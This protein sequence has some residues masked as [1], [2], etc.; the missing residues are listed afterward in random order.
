MARDPLTSLV[1]LFEGSIRVEHL[2]EELVCVDVADLARAHEKM[3]ELQIDVVG[4]REHSVIAGYIC[5]GAQEWAHFRAAELV[6]DSASLRDTLPILRERERLFVLKRNE[7]RWIITRADLQKAPFRL[8]C[9]GIVTLLEIR[10]LDL[11]RETYGDG[12]RDHLT[13]DR[14]EACERTHRG[15]AARREQMDLI[16]CLQLADKR[17]L[18]TRHDGLR[19]RLGFTS[20]RS[21][22]AMLKQAERLRDQLAHGQELD[23][24]QSWPE[25]IRLVVELEQ[26]LARP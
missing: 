7:V 15:R 18:V 22:E 19:E 5:R 14:L 8:F 16:D 3:D 9:F 11:V 24:G 23:N 13:A 12:F 21:A 20:K 4:V 26:L 17:E 25:V 10:L 1:S 6:A 2:M